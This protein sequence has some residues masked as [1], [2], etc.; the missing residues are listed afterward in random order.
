MNFDLMRKTH[1]SLLSSYIFRTV[2]LIYFTDHFLSNRHST[3]RIRVAKFVCSA[4]FQS[5][6]IHMLVPIINAYIVVVCTNVTP[7]ACYFPKLH[8]MSVPL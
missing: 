2:E 3:N 6:L 4:K 1:T 5:L 7:N 8:G